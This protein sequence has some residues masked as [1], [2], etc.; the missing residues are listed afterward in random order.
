M[1]F[2]L[3]TSLTR[4]SAAVE[5]LLRRECRAAGETI[6]LAAR[7]IRSRNDLDD[8]GVVLGPSGARTHLFRRKR[9]LALAQY[10]RARAVFKEAFRDHPTGESLRLWP[11][12]LKGGSN[13]QTLRKAKADRLGIGSCRPGRLCAIQ[14]YKRDSWG[15]A[16]AMFAASPK[17]CRNIGPLR[18]AASQIA[19]VMGRP[20][21]S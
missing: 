9:A 10:L 8:L 16:V 15:K 5:N 17:S 19:F 21:N 4:V 12:L 1:S 20:C 6:G 7:G 14:P 3:R 2:R 13:S 11:P 18:R